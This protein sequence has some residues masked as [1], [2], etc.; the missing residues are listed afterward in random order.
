MIAYAKKKKCKLY[1]TFIDF[2]KAYDLIPRIA[3]ITILYSYGC[4]LKMILAIQAMYSI[5]N[6]IIGST[7]LRIKKGVRQGAPS[8]GTLFTIFIDKLIRSLNNAFPTDG[9]LGF[10]NC[11]AFM[12]DLVIISTTRIGMQ[13]KLNILNSFCCNYNMFINVDKSKFFVINGDLQDNIPFTCGNI[14]IENTDNYTYLGCIFTSCGNIAASI[15]IHASNKFTNYLKLSNFLRVNCN[16]PFFIKKKVLEAAYNTSIFYGCISWFNLSPRA[17]KGLYNGGIKQLLGVRIATCNLLALC[18]ANY[19]PIEF[20]IKEIQS[21]CYRKLLYDNSRSIDDD[22]FL[23]IW[24]IAFQ[25]NVYY[26]KYMK[27]LADSNMN[28][29]TAGINHV[30]QMIQQSNSSKITTY[31]SINPNLI[32]H[33]IYISKDP[34][35]KEFHRIAFTKLRVSSHYLRVELGRWA[36]PIIPI[37]ERT[38]NCTTTPVIQ[39]EIHVFT[40]C[41]ITNNISLDFPSVN[42]NIP[43]I[44]NLS[45]A[46]L[47]CKICY[48][49]DSKFTR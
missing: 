23:H 19:P 11:L 36:R 10:L 12:D 6:I 34:T 31:L 4:S 17:M 21:K 2:K 33:P 44:F 26:A 25:E 45:D 16:F 18:E 22:P 28:Y 40:N 30:H 49:I 48:E 15:K 37:N 5:S 46:H 8:S 32:V 14:E 7:I 39:D 35:L 42:F 38:C 29:I 1:V 20:Y 24:N 13:T 3:I 43:E 9:F 41:L 27:T 47:L